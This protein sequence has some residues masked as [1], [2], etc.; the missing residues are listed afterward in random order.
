MLF[1]VGVTD[2]FTFV[3]VTVLFCVVALVATYVP[4]WRVTT[5]DPIAALRHE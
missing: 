4:A 5:L 2:L 1:G 3:T